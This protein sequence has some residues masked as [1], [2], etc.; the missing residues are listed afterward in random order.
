VAVEDSEQSVVLEEVVE[1][2][3]PVGECA[4]GVLD[5]MLVLEV[6]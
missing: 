5:G 2:L 6:E 1:A 3:E 4:P